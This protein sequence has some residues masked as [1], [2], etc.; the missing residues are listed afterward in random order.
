MF[1][2]FYSVDLE[3]VLNSILSSII[4]TSVDKSYRLVTTFCVSFVKAQLPERFGLVKLRVLSN[5]FHGLIATS[6]DRYTVYL[7]LARCSLILKNLNYLPHKLD[8][9]QKYLQLWNSRTE[10]IQA[11]YRILFEALQI[12]DSQ[13]AFKTMIELLSTYTKETSSKSRDD[14]HKCIVY[15][16]N[17]PNIFIFDSLL[18]LEPIKYLEGELIHNVKILFLFL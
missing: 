6:K 14:A 15:C 16:I 1:S 9:V 8:V 17:D 4:E 3:T 13:S 2:S 5:L 12:H 7:Y 11:L 10:D 18:L